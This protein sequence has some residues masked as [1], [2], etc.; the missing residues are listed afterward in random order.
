MCW[1]YRIWAARTIAKQRE[2]KITTNTF[3][4]VVSGV[5]LISFGTFFCKT[6]NCHKY[7]HFCHIFLTITLDL[8]DCMDDLDGCLCSDSVWWGASN[9]ICESCNIGGDLLFPFSGTGVADPLETTSSSL[10]P[11]VSLLDFLTP[12][13][14]SPPGR[15]ASSDPGTWKYCRS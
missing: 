15:S 10:D 14:I 1:L 7:F 13:S 4:A 8:M 2:N 5:F 3:K 12:T 9:L 11:S 6:I